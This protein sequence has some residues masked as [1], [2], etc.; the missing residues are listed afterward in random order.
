MFLTPPVLTATIRQ[1]KTLFK[2][3]CILKTVYVVPEREQSCTLVP[4]DIMENIHSLRVKLLVDHRNQVWSFSIISSNN[5]HYHS[6]YQHWVWLKGTSNRQWKNTRL[7]TILILWC[8]HVSLK[9]QPN[10][11]L[12]RP[13]QKGKVVHHGIHIRSFQEEFW[14]SSIY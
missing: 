6:L 4:I 11:K 9:S 5:S 1:H 2:C 10:W 3:L 7:S 14:T 8:T 12:R 13:H